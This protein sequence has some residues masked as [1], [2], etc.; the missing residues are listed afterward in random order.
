M[1]AA[2]E[3]VKESGARATAA[4]SATMAAPESRRDSR[5]SKHSEEATHGTEFRERSQC[6]S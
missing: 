5:C 2:G 1:R 6:Y 3:G 4:M